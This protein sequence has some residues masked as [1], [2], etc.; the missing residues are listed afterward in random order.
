MNICVTGCLGFIGFNIVNNLS[1]RKNI[2]IFGIDNLDN[3]IYPINEKKEKLKAL[4]KLRNFNFLK[5]DISSIISLNSF[6]KKNKISYTINLAGQASVRNS[7]KDYN[8]FI[9]DNILGFNNIISLCNK[10]NSKLIY[11]STSSV[12]NSKLNRCPNSIKETNYRP[13]SIYGL[14]KYM[15][16]LTSDIYY[17]EYGFKSLGL[18]FFTVYGDY[19]RTD[20]AIFKFIDGIFKSKKIKLYNFGNYYRDFVHIDLINECIDKIIFKKMYDHRVYNLGDTNSIKLTTL[21]K[22]LEK[23]IGKKARISL[24]PPLIDEPIK[25]QADMIETNIF[26]KGFNQKS[27]DEGLKQTVQWYKKNY[28]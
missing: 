20:M 7:L 16:E 5:I 26:F 1:K 23:I 28:L 11:A 10:Y 22:K 8:K 18:R 24:D 9:K 4:K 13:Q 19:P 6:Y 14:S 3:S 12:Y 2:N 25:T 17:Q 15:N 27:I 21:I